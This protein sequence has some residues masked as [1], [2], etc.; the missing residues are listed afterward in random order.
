DNEV[1]KIDARGSFQFYDV[2]RLW[3]DIAIALD[4]ELSLVHLPTEPATVGEIA[5]A[6]FGI[7][8]TNELEKPPARYDIHTRFASMFGGRDPYVEPKSVVLAGISTWVTKE[9]SSKN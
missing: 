6:A 5:Q 2:A 1:T 4:N 3:R 8:F 9:R 7:A